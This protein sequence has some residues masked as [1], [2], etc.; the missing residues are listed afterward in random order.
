MKVFLSVISI[1]L[2]F[3]GCDIANKIAQSPRMQ[4]LRDGVEVFISP[5]DSVYNSILLLKCRINNNNNVP[6]AFLG[7]NYLENGIMY[8][9]QPNWNPRI[10]FNNIEQSEFPTK[11]IGDMITPTREAFLEIAPKQNFDFEIL[12]DLKKLFGARESISKDWINKK[13]G[14][15]SVTIEYKSMS[16]AHEEALLGTIQSNTIKVK[17]VSE[18]K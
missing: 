5:N 9:H 12:I 8:N 13:Y 18:N 10:L 4:V 2:L 6:V 14:Y 11:L 1:W 16:R 7:L 3:T 17:Y 15:Y